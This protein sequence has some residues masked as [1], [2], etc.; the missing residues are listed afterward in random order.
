MPERQQYP[1]KNFFDPGTAHPACMVEIEAVAHGFIDM[2]LY[3]FHNPCVCSEKHYFVL[4]PE[5]AVI[6]IRRAY[7]KSFAINKQKLGMK[8]TK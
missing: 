3:F 8:V 5:A 4:I 1:P 2:M 7:A 6:N